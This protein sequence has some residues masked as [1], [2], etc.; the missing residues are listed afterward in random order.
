[1]AKELEDVPD[2]TS[3]EQLEQALQII[4]EKRYSAREC[5]AE[6]TK[7]LKLLIRKQSKAKKQIFL[8]SINRKPKPFIQLKQDF[9]ELLLSCTEE[10][11][12][13][14]QRIDFKA[15][16]S[17]LVGQRIRQKFIEDREE[18]WYK[19]YVVSYNNDLNT[20]EIVYTDDSEHYS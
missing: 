7:L 8:F 16:P 19:G 13:K 14:R 18:I 20:H 2:I 1:M 6:K 11:P 4:E 15:N 10:R 5:E 9:L 12:A 3:E 17:L